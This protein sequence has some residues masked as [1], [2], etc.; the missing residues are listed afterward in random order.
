[1]LTKIPIFMSLT[2]GILYPLGF[3]LHYPDPIVSGFRRFN[4]G[5]SNFVGGLGVIGLLFQNISYPIKYLALIWLGLS[6]LVC[7]LSWNK[8]NT[9]PHLITIPVLIGIILLG[10]LHPAYI[11]TPASQIWSTLLGGG[12]LCGV[13]FT[14]V[15]GHWYLTVPGLSLS[16]LVRATNVF[17]FFVILRFFLDLIVIFIVYVNHLGDQIP[18]YLFTQRMDGILLWVAF[19]FGTLLP[20]ICTYFV[21]ETLK[22]KSTQSATGILYAIL[23]AVFMGEL[24]YKYYLFE[25]G[26]AL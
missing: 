19:L 23:L 20:L 7:F 17:W 21:K 8:K 22:V 16:H 25:F 13:V 12:I 9:N 18:I 11:G 14:T 6:L 5:L 3:W 4:L 10:K 26:I 15:L 24:S 1:M 2:F